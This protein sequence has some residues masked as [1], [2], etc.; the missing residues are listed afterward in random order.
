MKRVAVFCG[1]SSGDKAIYLDKARQLGYW[2]ADREI[3]LVYGGATV[4]LM[5][6]CADAV[7]ERGGKVIGVIPELLQQREIAHSHLSELYVVSSM[8]ERK[9]K[10]MEL[11]DGFIALPGGTGTME[12][13]FEAITWGQIGLHRKPCA[14]YNIGGYYDL[15]TVF[16]DQMVHSQFLSSENRNKIIIADFIESIERQFES[17]IPPKVKTY[18]SR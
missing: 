9:A 11:A 3:E 18:E 8:H 14:F 12:E 1:S 6:A 7:L 17:Y 13:I 4:G 10:M 16:L 5:G 15:L 2:L